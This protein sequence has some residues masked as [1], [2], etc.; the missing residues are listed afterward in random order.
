MVGLYLYYFINEMIWLPPLI[1]K[2]YTIY[3]WIQNNF[4]SKFKHISEKDYDS[5]GFNI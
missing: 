5:D 1:A 4:N 3:V 2:Q